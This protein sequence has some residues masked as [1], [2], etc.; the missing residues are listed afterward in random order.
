MDLQQGRPR[1]GRR[2]WL[3]PVV[4]GLA[5]GAIGLA[6]I[7]PAFGPGG[8]L[9]TP[10]AAMNSS[11]IRPPPDREALGWNVLDPAVLRVASWV[12]GSEDHRRHPFFIVDKTG[13]R[14]HAFDADGKLISM[15]PVLI[16][17]A[18]GDDSAPGI[19]DRALDHI[20]PA[21]RTTPAGRFL[22]ELGSNSLG[23]EVVW[24]DH[25]AAVSMHAVRAL[26]ASERR[27]ERIA[28][29]GVDDNRISF[30]CINV[31]A[32]FFEGFV[33]PAF[34]RTRAFVY[35]MPDTKR[36]EEVFPGFPG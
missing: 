2:S 4:Q 19:G 12:V 22:S 5:V 6:A 31:P 20:L 16:G 34:T 24:V 35:V 27:H 18:R 1:D 30:G 36:L 17:A 33:K 32:A 29:P 8:W 14:L 13:A 9:S 25:G 10:A 15:T 21:E 23:E 11:S 28:S 3:K 26:V 7:V